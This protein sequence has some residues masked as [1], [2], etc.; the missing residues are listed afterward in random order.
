METK[1]R[2]IIVMEPRK[3]M[4]TK[5]KAGGIGSVYLAD[6]DAD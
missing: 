5:L 4:M 3:M 1:A 2:I 6:F